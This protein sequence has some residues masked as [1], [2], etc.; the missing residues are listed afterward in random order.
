VRQ[1][2]SAACRFVV[3]RAQGERGDPSDA[4]HALH[5]SIRRNGRSAG[6]L[7]MHGAGTPQPIGRIVA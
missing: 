6:P 3:I 4:A 5:V 2:V 7:V 1:W